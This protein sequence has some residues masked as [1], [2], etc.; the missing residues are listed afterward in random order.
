[1]QTRIERYRIYRNEIAS[2]ST[3]IDK[4]TATSVVIQNYKKNI[5]SLSPHI[6]ANINDNKALAKLI[7]INN[8]KM[9]ELDMLNNFVNLIE[10]SKATTLMTEIQD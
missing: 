9:Q 2:E 5:D 1:M 4:I 8:N 3:L 7:S 10:Q 6:L